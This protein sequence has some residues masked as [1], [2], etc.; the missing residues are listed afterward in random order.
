MFA[1]E[2]KA[3]TVS[4][5]YNITAAINTMFTIAIPIKNTVSFI[6][7]PYNK[8]CIQ[9]KTDHFKCAKRFLVFPATLF[10]DVKYIIALKLFD[11]IILCKHSKYA[12]GTAF[13]GQFHNCQS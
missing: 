5:H 2:P 10:N 6:L 3:Y 13:N 9:V 8:T 11:T 1:V 12:L 7:K 4:A